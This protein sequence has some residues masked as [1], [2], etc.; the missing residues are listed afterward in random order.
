LVISTD[1]LLFKQMKDVRKEKLFFSSF[2]YMSSNQFY[3]DLTL[4]PLR[5]IPLTL[6]KKK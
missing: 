5:Q 4:I 2:F 6:E 1:E 3:I